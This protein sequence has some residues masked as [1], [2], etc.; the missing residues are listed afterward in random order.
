M[1]V[2]CAGR[3]T[4][5]NIPKTGHADGSIGAAGLLTS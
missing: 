5:V 2:V 4:E 3:L 1:T